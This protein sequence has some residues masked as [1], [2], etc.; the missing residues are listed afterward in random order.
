MKDFALEHPF[1]TLLI[2]GMLLATLRAIIPWARRER[3][4]DGGN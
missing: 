4:D 3:D 1:Y 2:V